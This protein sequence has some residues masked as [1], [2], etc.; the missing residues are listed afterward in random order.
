MFT[1]NAVRSAVAAVL[2]AVLAYPRT[3]VL[4]YSRRSLRDRR[5]QICSRL[6]VQLRRPVYIIRR[7]T[8]EPVD[9]TVG[10]TSLRRSIYCIQRLTAECFLI[11]VSFRSGPVEIRAT[12][13]LH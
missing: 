12:G 2:M 3:E 8:L 4:G 5:K 13:A 7:L 6:R 1:S 11:I 9:W 10:L